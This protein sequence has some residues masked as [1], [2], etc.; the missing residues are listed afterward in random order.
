MAGAGRMEKEIKKLLLQTTKEAVLLKRRFPPVEQPATPSFFGGYPRLPADVD[1]PRGARGHSLNFL[2]QVD[3]AMLPKVDER[4]RLPERG[5]LFVFYDGAQWPDSEFRLTYA[6]AA[7]NDTP[8]RAPPADT[9]PLR[10]R[11]AGAAASHERYAVSDFCYEVD[12]LRM[13]TFGALFDAID[14]IACDFDVDE[15]DVL[16]A[17][18]YLRD[19]L[20]E[21]ELERVLGKPALKT[22][23]AL[24][25]VRRWFE[26][27]SYPFNRVFAAN[28][29]SALQALIR[30]GLERNASEM[31]RSSEYERFCREVVEETKRWRSLVAPTGAS[32]LIEAE[33]RA[34]F[35]LWISA[36]PKRL[37][38]A[39]DSVKLEFAGS[40]DLVALL[41]RLLSASSL[42]FSAHAAADFTLKTLLVSHGTRL[43]GCNVPRPALADF[44][45][46]H[47]Q[48]RAEQD[49]RDDGKPILRG[50]PYALHQMFGHLPQIQEPGSETSG[51]TWFL[52][53]AGD[54]AFA[55]H[56]DTGS[57]LQFWGR[58]DEIARGDFRNVVVERPI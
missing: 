31:P 35:A 45:Y 1:W 55:C 18:G 33:Q 7:T 46:E 19:D 49:W 57:A 38:S 26:G 9:L 30:E 51:L 2:A 42:R 54:P 39:L 47:A 16:E 21:G 53:L 56:N 29:L 34:G 44:E 37:V 50:R 27:E 25:D 41:S 23:R 28:H 20:I 36:L 32:L 17:E 40:P 12:F 4:R 58:A 5:V 48:F 24:T 10:S 14:D 11:W 43:Q 6:A 3:L 52:H 15:N 8:V 13:R 22:P